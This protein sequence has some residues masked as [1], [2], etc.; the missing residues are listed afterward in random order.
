MSCVYQ[1]KFYVIGGYGQGGIYLSDSW[2]YDCEAS[3][4]AYFSTRNASSVPAGWLLPPMHSAAHCLLGDTLYAFGGITQKG[5]HLGAMVMLD[6]KTAQWTTQTFVGGPRSRWGSSLVEYSGSLYLFAGFGDSFYSDLWRFDPT[7][8]TWTELQPLGVPPPRHYHSAVVWKD[9]MYIIGGYRG[10]TFTADVW[11]YD[12]VANRWL[13]VAGTSTLSNR[14]GHTCVVLP[15]RS[16]C[17]VF[18]GRDD[19]RRLNDILEFKFEDA[20]FQVLRSAGQ[21]PDSRVFH[22]SFLFQNSL[23]S[24]GG[25]NVYN[26]NDILEYV[27]EPTETKATQ[28]ARGSRIDYSPLWKSQ[29]MA[30]VTF[31]F[32]STDPTTSDKQV[33]IP[34]HK[35]IL[36]AASEHFRRLFNSGM[37]ES[38]DGI[39]LITDTS[40]ETFEEVLH[41]I[42]TGTL[43][44]LTTGNVLD[45]LIA[46]DKYLL[47]ELVELLEKAL[48][49][50]LSNDNVASILSL[51]STIPSATSTYNR[52]IA[53]LRAH[54]LSPSFSKCKKFLKKHDRALYDELTTLHDQEEEKERKR[55]ERAITAAQF[56]ATAKSSKGTQATPLSSSSS[57]V[58]AASSSNSRS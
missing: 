52:C 36:Y 48:G 42:Y 58:N 4:W 54:I 23:L 9:H 22:A 2:V 35:V 46:A 11:S 56:Q 49:Y 18:G 45:L 21:I 55:Q 53:F 40:P 5:Q 47:L 27:L 57:Q 28:I 14:R 30:D 37:R 16:S 17:I 24:F 44:R 1:N 51:T 19:K 39:I 12:F 8:G 34:A 3:S 13:R 38:T 15:H 50:I 41:F 6:M 25:L 43:H 7:S 10:S 33:T 32:P 29:I 20:S 26:T 31:Q